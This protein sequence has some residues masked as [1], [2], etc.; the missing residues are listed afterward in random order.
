MLLGIATDFAVGLLCIILGLLIWKKKKISILHRYHYQN[1]RKED[2]P[3]YAKM[4]GIGQIIIGIALCLAGA[5]N[6]FSDSLWWIPMVIGL[7]AG[8]LLMHKA[9]MKYNGSWFS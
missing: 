8:F 6:L 2:I 9:Q 3:C 1:V 7:V 5:V 4:M